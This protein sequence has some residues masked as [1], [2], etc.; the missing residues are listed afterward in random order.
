MVDAY[1][2][3]EVAEFQ[4]EVSEKKDARFSSKFTDTW[5][6]VHWKAT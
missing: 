5:N 3:E 4:A 2:L 1:V 6:V